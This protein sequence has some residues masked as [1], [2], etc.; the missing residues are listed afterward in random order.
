MAE[1]RE[2]DLNADVGEG[3]DDALLLPYV[4]SVN[5]ACG[6]HAGDE[7]T[8]R[9][10][11]RA[12]AAAGVS[13]GAHPSFPDREGFG[14]AVTTKDPSE[15]AELVR[16]QSRRLQSIARSEGVDLVHVK[17]HGALYNLAAVDRTVAD[18]VA[19]GVAAL[20]RSVALVGL[21]GSSSLAAAEARGLRAV[22]EAFVD[23]AYSPEGTLV[24]RS[25]PGAVIEDAEQAARRAVDIA[26]D[27]RVETAAGSFLRL[28]AQT[29]CLHGDTAGARAIAARVAAELASAGVR[30]VSCGGCRPRSS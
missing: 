29:L 22:A 16:T 25:E 5:V 3:Y 15:I 1:E 6:A 19:E 21:A 30:V 12:A 2:V 18:A 23:R 28:R 27:G 8:M 14:R 20:G 26:R 11:V 17:P 9:R 4:S 7:S 13:V 10:T 24:P